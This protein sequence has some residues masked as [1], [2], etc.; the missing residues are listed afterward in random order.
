M[1]QK[2][3]LCARPLVKAYRD[4]AALEQLLQI[5]SILQAIAPDVKPEDKPNVITLA[6]EESHSPDLHIR[7]EARRLGRQFRQAT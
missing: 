4:A 2:G 1:R 5:L 7:V 6:D 3:G